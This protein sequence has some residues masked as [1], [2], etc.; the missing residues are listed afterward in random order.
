MDQKP[1]QRAP[2]GR[3]QPTEFGD[4]PWSRRTLLEW[5]GKGAVLALA[6]FDLGACAPRRQN[7]CPS[8]GTSGLNFDPG[9]CSSSI[10]ASWPENTADPQNLAQILATWTL[11]VDGQVDNP[12]TLT[13]ADLLALPR[14][15]LVMDFH[16]VEG[17]SV[18]D[19]PWNGVHMSQ[20]TSLVSPHASATYVNFYCIDGIYSESLPLA[21]ALEPHTFLGYGIDG[22]SLPLAHG[23]PL[24]V[25]IPRLFGYKGAKYLTRIEL[26]D[27]PLQGFWEA[28]GYSSDGQVPAALL[29]PG[30]Y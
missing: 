17:W 2:I 11:S 29:R 19:V 25:V 13:F 30:K 6:G 26:T 1:W 28:Y 18:Q 24:R 5:L 22:N 16:C 9:P 15:D 21:V 27:Q 7:S 10:F 4:R 8:G 20:L 3:A 14:T 12:M 23:F